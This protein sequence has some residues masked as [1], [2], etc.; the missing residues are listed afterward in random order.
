MKN[1]CNHNEYA[2]KIKNVYFPRKKLRNIIFIS[3]LCSLFDAF[4]LHC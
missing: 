2:K 3:L 4:F 1:K